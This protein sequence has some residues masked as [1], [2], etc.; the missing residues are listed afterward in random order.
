MGDIQLG[1]GR[2]EIGWETWSLAGVLILSFVTLLLI[3]WRYTERTRRRAASNKQ[4]ARNSDAIEAAVD[5]LNPY[6][7]PRSSGD[8][9]KPNRRAHSLNLPIRVAMALVGVVVISFGV[10]IAIGPIA[11]TRA[12][13]VRPAAICLV[14]GGTCL[15]WWAV[16]RD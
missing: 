14:G 10:I 5:D 6:R 16:G 12:W 3:A 13:F 11:K 15:A 2:G 8:S 4:I 7:S 1:V 9:L